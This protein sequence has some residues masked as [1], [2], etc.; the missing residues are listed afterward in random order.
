ML[1]PEG[2]ASH[3]ELPLF[4]G[5]DQL[6]FVAGFYVDCQLAVGSAQTDQGVTEETAV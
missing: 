1:P 4:V 3:F 2:W 6:D 5:M